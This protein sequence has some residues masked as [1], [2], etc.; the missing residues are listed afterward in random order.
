R[1]TRGRVRSPECGVPSGHDPPEA[2]KYHVALQRVVGLAFRQRSGPP[3]TLCAALRTGETTAGGLDDFFSFAEADEVG[4][5]VDGGAAAC[6]GADGFDDFFCVQSAKHTGD[7]GARGGGG[8]EVEVR[9]LKDGAIEHLV[10]Q[11][12]G[13][14]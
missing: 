3:A 12:H 8:G 10:Q 13:E 2:G 5:C 11:R 14:L 6:A 4:E 1:S 7:Y 9:A